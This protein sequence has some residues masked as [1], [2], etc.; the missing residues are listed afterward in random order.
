M[1]RF[2]RTFAPAAFALALLAFSGCSAANSGPDAGPAYGVNIVK[3]CAGEIDHLN[4]DPALPGFWLVGSDATIQVSRVKDSESPKTF[5]FMLRTKPDATETKPSE[6]D[7]LRILTP[8][9]RLVTKFNPTKIEPVDIFSYTEKKDG[10]AAVLVKTDS[11]GKYIA[12]E[13]V[14]ERIKVTLTAEALAILG[15][16]MAISLD[17]PAPQEKSRRRPVGRRD[18]TLASRP[19]RPLRVRILAGNFPEKNH[20]PTFPTNPLWPPLNTKTFSAMSRICAITGKRPTKGRRIIHKGQSKKSRGIGLQLV[21]KA[22][23]AHLQAEP[24]AHPREAA[25]R[26]DQAPLETSVKALKA[27]LVTKA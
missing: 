22:D 5:R 14:G 12:F 15:P 26:L 24:A 3:G 23:Q 16:D 21:K 13:R 9:Y 25:E 2:S 6:I 8:N 19:L 27:G 1:N 10:G 11:T 20:L 18:R 7:V 4:Y 17:R